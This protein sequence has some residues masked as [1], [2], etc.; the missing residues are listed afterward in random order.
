MLRNNLT[1]YAAAF[2]TI[3]AVSAGLYPAA[4]AGSSALVW[5]LLGLAVAAVGFTL[6]TK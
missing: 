1:R 3:C 5:G 4:S 6:A 2:L